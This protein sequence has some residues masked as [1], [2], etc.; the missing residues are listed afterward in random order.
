MTSRYHLLLA[1]VALW[2]G[3]G[4]AALAAEPKAE[5]R[6]EIDSELRRQL[7]RAVGQVDT[8]PANRFEARRRARSAM[9][10]AQALL[11]S[12]GY[13]QPSLED[14]VE[15]EEKP[16]AVVTVTPGRR[17]VLAETQINWSAPAPDAVTE[18]VVTKDL[19]LKPGGPGRAADILDAEGRIVA[20]LTREGYADAKAEPRRVVVD[21][22]AFTVQ[23]NFNI[24]SGEVVR[25]DGVL[26][27]TRGPTNPDWVAN[28]APWRA[29]DRYDPEDVAELERRLLDTGVYDGVNVSLAPQ[30]QITPEG[31]RPV[32]VGL[33]D[34]PRSLLEA[35][36][37]YSTAEGVGVDVFRTRYN[38]FGRAATLKY[39]LRFASIDSRLGGEASF[40]HFR[41][42]GRTLKLSSYLV[43]EQ[44]DAYDRSA[45]TV[46]ADLSQ[47]IGKTSFF[48]YG[49]GI[50]AGR[51]T[52]NRFD[53]VTQAPITFDRDLAILTGRA[54]AFMDRSNDPLDPTTGYRLYVSAQPT[55]VTGEDTVLF[56]R[57]E[58]Q[59]TGYLPLQDGAK[60]V[61]AGRARIG[62][63]IGGQE[64]T[65][66]S[67]RLFYSGGGGS[68]RGYSYQSINPRLPDNTPRGGLSLFE[69][70]IEIRRDIGAK[71]QAVGFIDAG[72]IGFQETPNF[73]NL[74]YG[75]GVGVRYKLPFGPIRA[76]IAIP[77]DKRE[78]DADFQLYISIGQAF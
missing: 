64:L 36:A 20:G 21:H 74:R 69:T 28:L 5:I 55:A 3:C 67:D 75:A 12:E 22:A 10:S 62:S 50:D 11:R 33:S 49:L 37:T 2:A 42:P 41:K 27:R 13:Y 61:L 48:T 30:D 44:T 24:A 1:T 46:N 40:P 34:R 45:L 9:E 60:T 76:D 19:A 70:S 72:A 25:L 59:A 18:Q 26:V 56:L 77:L 73:N 7:E 57:T 8:P 32:I 51:Y 17:F 78:G 43:N 23:P 71:F 6:G 14:D 4:H 29:G 53:P 16:V 39:G 47:R 63:I 35:G 65:V 66:P 68:V 31:L 52:E 15:G 58:A 54:I 38:R